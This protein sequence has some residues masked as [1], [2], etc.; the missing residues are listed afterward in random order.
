MN[1]HNNF[2]SIENITTAEH[3]IAGLS[4]ENQLIVQT[5]LHNKKS[6]SYKILTHI[7]KVTQSQN[8]M[9][10]ISTY[11]ELNCFDKFLFRI[12]LPEYLRFNN[13]NV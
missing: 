13:I 2:D 5:K 9:C 12:K 1:L 6:A 11:G 7:K 8:I 4:L 10:V 3:M